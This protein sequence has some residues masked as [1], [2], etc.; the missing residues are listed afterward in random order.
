MSILDDIAKGATDAVNLAAKKTGEVTNVAKMKL[1]LH[2]EESKLEDCYKEIGKLYH[3]AQRGSED[4][5][6]VLEGKL[7]E[8]DAL[9]KKI[10]N[11][12]KEI[13]DVQ[14]SVVCKSCQSKI[15]KAFEFCPIC[16][17]K[18]R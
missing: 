8:A 16:G 13:S 14:D 15:N 2:T 11:I 1:A 6:S 5:S 17:A 7:A 18:Q 4:N 3:S 12:K 10:A 9:V